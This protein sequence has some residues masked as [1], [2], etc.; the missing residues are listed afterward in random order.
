[1]PKLHWPQDQGWQVPPPLT[2][3]SPLPQVLVILTA[4][5]PSIFSV[6]A[7]TG[8]IACSPPF[9]SKTRSQGKCVGLLPVLRVSLGTEE[10]REALGTEVAQA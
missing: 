1:M 8:Q 9:P 4:L 3:A 6:L 10:G 2:P 7:S 5:Q